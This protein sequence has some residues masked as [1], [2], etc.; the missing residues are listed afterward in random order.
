MQTISTLNIG[1]STGG[2]EQNYLLQKTIPESQISPI[3]I[4]TLSTLLKF[5]VQITITNN[6]IYAIMGYQMHQ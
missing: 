5:L 2:I 4:P 6:I 1:S 3:T